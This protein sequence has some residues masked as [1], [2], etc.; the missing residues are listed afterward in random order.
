[1][2]VNVPEAL[3]S[4]T[5]IP[6]GPNRMRRFFESPIRN[7]SPLREQRDRTPVNAPEALAPRTPI[8]LGPNRMRR[9]FESPVRNTSPLREQRGRTPVNAPEA[10]APRTHI[11]L[12]PNRM[13]R[14]SICRFAH[15]RPELEQ[16]HPSPRAFV[17]VFFEHG[18]TYR[19]LYSFHF[20]SWDSFVYMIAAS[21]SDSVLR[22][23]SLPFSVH[24]F[25]RSSP[26]SRS[27]LVHHD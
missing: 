25:F 2:P 16:G 12:G 4:R 13:R 15:F 18:L 1:M 9:F 6:L 7:T 17:L 23:R 20:R 22:Y 19:L 27:R 24:T 5:P 3:A 10:L 11:P 21:S 26:R 8:P 14:F